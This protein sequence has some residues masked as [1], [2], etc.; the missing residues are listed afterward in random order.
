MCGFLALIYDIFT[1]LTKKQK[2]S[3]KKFGNVKYFL[4]S[5]HKFRKA[6]TFSF[7]KFQKSYKKNPQKN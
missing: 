4:L 7:V 1:F 5:L 2:I 3:A 6:S